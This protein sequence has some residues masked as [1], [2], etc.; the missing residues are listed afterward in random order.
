LRAFLYKFMSLVIIGTVAF[1]A[2][3]TPFG[4]TDKIVG[5]A[6]TYASLAASYFYE[7]V[8]IVGVVGDDFHKKDILEFVNH[9]IDVEGLQIKDGEKSF[10]WAG[11]YHNDM[12][13]RDTL[14][15]E[16]NVLADFDPV[17]PESYQDCQYL[18]LGNLTPKI[19]QT[20]IKRLRKRPKLIV[21]D[22][23]NFWMDVAM[24]DLLETIKLIDV[25]TINDAEARQLSGE[26]SLVKAARKILQMGPQ[27][28]VIKKGEHG[29]LLFHEDLIFSA[30][31]LPLADVFD[32]TGAGDT[33]AGGFIGYLAKVG[34]VNF[35][36]MKNA[37]I[38]GSALASFCV[39]KFGTERIINLKAEQ[40]SSRIREFINLSSFVIEQ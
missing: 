1:D 5:G 11:K 8:K 30:P 10:F 22:T 21:M 25:L 38:Y 18:L 13:S 33:F 39:E 27:Y 29:A 17:I 28:L 37:I 2:I 6:A 34:T 20:T 19:Q 3:E 24:D 14:V 4:K 9:G 23:M 36:N 35:N 40:V 31:A 12:N 26:Y 15:T 16:L 7:K 32:P